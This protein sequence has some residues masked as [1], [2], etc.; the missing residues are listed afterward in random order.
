MMDYQEQRL[1]DA[2]RSIDLKRLRSLVVVAAE[3]DSR[4]IIWRPRPH[5]RIT[6]QHDKLVAHGIFPLHFPP[7]RIKTDAAGII[8]EIGQ[9]I[10]QGLQRPPLPVKGLSAA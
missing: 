3:V 1:I 5:D 7:D 8:R 6:E 9:A 2:G 4:A 10:Q